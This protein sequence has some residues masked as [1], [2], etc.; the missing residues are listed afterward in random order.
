MN[1]YSL[2]QKKQRI[3]LPYVDKEGMPIVQLKPEARIETIKS[4]KSLEFPQVST[5]TCPRLQEIEDEIG[6][7]LAPMEF[8]GKLDFSRIETTVTKVPEDDV[9]RLHCALGH[10]HY[11]KIQE[12]GIK[13]SK[14]NI[15]KIQRCKTCAVGKFTL[16]PTTGKKDRTSIK[17]FERLHMDTA[18]P[19]TAFGS[20]YW[21]ALLIDDY[22]RY[23]KVFVVTKKT[24]IKP[25]IER[26]LENE[27]KVR[28][29]LTEIYYY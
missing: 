2:F 10:M 17:P 1:Y 8:I 15:K 23:L 9:F 28:G 16:K 27:E 24:D 26:Y 21:M 19:I 13:L 3:S 6:T 5:G 29:Y 4:Y 14:E 25:S 20:K 12:M 11:K 18:G 7:E 22:S